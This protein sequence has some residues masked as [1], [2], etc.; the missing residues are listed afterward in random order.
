[1]RNI[2]T[3]HSF[4]V[5]SRYKEDNNSSELAFNHKKREDKNIFIVKSQVNITSSL[6]RNHQKKVITKTTETP[7][8]DTKNLFTFPLSE[9]ER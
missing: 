1:M 4:S 7:Q 8:D 6:R 3:F 5:E 2:K 9:S